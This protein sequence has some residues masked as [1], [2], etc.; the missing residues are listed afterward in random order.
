[1]YYV[2][3]RLGLNVT[4]KPLQQ[5]YRRRIRQAKEQEDGRMRKALT[6]YAQQTGGGRGM[7]GKCLCTLLY[8]EM[9][10]DGVRF[11]MS[12]KMFGKSL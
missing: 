7:P 11:L 2:A 3:Q 5:F 4:K 10:W 8:H 1:M 6:K 12:H 9:A